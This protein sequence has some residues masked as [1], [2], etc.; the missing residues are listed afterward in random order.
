MYIDIYIYMEIICTSVLYLS[1]IRRPQP[2]IPSRFHLPLLLPG[3][4]GRGRQPFN[5]HLFKI[6][7][8]LY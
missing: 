3:V 5:I 7:N 2:P 8:A 6:C 4:G 1:V